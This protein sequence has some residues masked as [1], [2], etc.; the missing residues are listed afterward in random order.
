MEWHLCRSNQCVF[1]FFFIRLEAVVQTC[2]ATKFFLE[3]LQNPQEN[4]CAR[5]K[6]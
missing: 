6:C 1:R 5:V 3:I 2:S 4:I